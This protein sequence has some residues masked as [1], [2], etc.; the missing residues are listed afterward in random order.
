MN[1][2]GFRKLAKYLTEEDITTDEPHVGLRCKENNLTLNEIKDMLLNQ[3][4]RLVRIVKDR[5]GVY[6]LYYKRKRGVELKIVIDIFQHGKLNV[7]TVKKLDNRFKV[8]NVIVRRR[9]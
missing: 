9:F 5:P 3:N 6:K 2:E 7:R 1:V 4:Y 8:R